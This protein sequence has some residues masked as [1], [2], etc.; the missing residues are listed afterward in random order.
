MEQ[1]KWVTETEAKLKQEVMT[2]DVL[3]TLVRQGSNLPQNRALENVMSKV[4]MMLNKA[5]EWE[6][7]V[8]TAL[9]QK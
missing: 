9:K 8:K 6:Q 5:Q 3:K 1:V 4:K 2:I 7:K